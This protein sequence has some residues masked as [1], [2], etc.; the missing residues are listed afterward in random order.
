MDTL[1]SSLAAHQKRPARSPALSLTLQ[2]S[3]HG[4]PIL[5]FARYYSGAE[6]NGPAA[7]ALSAAGSLIRAR[8]DAGT[9]YLSRVA[10]PGPLSTYSSWTSIDTGATPGTGVALCALP[11]ELVLVY[12]SSSGTLLR[13]R[14]STDDGVTWSSASTIVTEATNPISWVALGSYNGLNNNTTAFYLTQPFGDKTLL[15]RVRRTSGIWQTAATWTRTADIEQLTGLAATHNGADY[16]VLITGTADTTLRIHTWGA[17]MGDLDLPPNAWSTLTP[18]VEF[19]AASTIVLSAPSIT[20]IANNT[21]ATYAQQ[22]TGDVATRRNQLTLAQAANADAFLEP[23]PIEANNTHEAGVAT[24][25]GNNTNVWMATANGVW[26]ATVGQ[27]RDLGSRLIAARWTFGPTAHTAEF[28]LDNTDGQ[29]FADGELPPQPGMDL[30]LF[31]GYRSGAAGAAQFGNVRSFVVQQV[32]HV[33][34]SV[35]GAR[36]VRIRCGG[37][38]TTLRRWR[39]PR[40]IAIAESTETRLQLLR[41]YAGRAGIVLVGTGGADFTSQQPGFAL[42]PGESADV[43]VQRLMSPA[44]EVLRTESGQLNLA[45]APT[46]PSEEYGGPAEHPVNSAIALTPVSEH[47]W[48]RTVGPDRY[49][50][51]HD[52][53]AIAR[54]GQAFA[55]SRQLFATTDAIAEAYAERTLERLQRDQPALRLTVPYHAGQTLWDVVTVTVPQLDIAAQD[56]RVVG[57]TAIYE[58]GPAG[59]KFEHILELGE[60]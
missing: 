53:E 27:S 17:L 34:D 44:N 45:T 49:A 32:E 39:A 36:S 8:N 33:W 25:R 47:N 12:V 20:R 30:A 58:R 57:L 59:V 21:V 5:N 24:Y 1:A 13:T 22:E 31:A 51:A 48:H 29:L 4:R 60:V 42:N 2:N 40:A 35:K 54:E 23:Y 41:R 38:W 50:D 16:E 14:N 6:A 3:R 28:T 56:Y 15:R 11:G 9:I 46:A 55:V 26:H 43:A 37:P 7:A 10:S 52:F 18:I 19:D